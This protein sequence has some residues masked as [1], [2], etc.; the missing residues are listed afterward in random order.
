MKLKEQPTFCF[1]AH[2]FPASSTLILDPEK[3]GVLNELGMLINKETEA[4][5]KLAIK[6][7]NTM[8]K[9]N[10]PAAA[11]TTGNEDTEPYAPSTYGKKLLTF[12]ANQYF[13]LKL[14]KLN[15]FFDGYLLNNFK[16]KHFLRGSTQ[17]LYLTYYLLSGNRSQ[18]SQ[19]ASAIRY[20]ANQ[21][22]PQLHETNTNLR[23]LY[24]LMQEKNKKN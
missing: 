20:M 16:V 21:T 11:T 12:L 6:S 7:K 5:N 8:K 23:N 14:L 18:Q 10:R 13:L 3:R 17:I 22:G 1:Y 24:S 15:M 19:V 2:I 9:A 4:Q